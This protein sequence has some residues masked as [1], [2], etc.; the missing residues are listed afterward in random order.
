MACENQRRQPLVSQLPDRSGR[1]TFTPANARE[2]VY[3]LH[4]MYILHP[5]VRLPH[6]CISIRIYFCIYIHMRTQI[7]QRTCEKGCASRKCE[8]LGRMRACERDV[9]IQEEGGEEVGKKGYGGDECI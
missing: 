9:H 3:T 7:R 5:R 2:P 4:K 6:A 1:R 8:R